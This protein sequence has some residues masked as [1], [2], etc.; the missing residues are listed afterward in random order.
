MTKQLF[1]AVATGQNVANLPPILELANPGDEV[2]WLQSREA[3]KGEWTAGADQVLKRFG[4]SVRVPLT[5][6]DIN[7][8]SRV[9][10]EIRKHM[11]ETSGRNLVLV[12]NGGP[13]LTTVGA[14]EAFKEREPLLVY[15][16]ERPAE[17][18][19]FPNGLAGSRKVKTYTRHRLDL[20]DV[21]ACRNSVLT[22]KVTEEQAK[23]WPEHRARILA[24]PLR[25]GEDEEFTVAC[26]RAWA[27][28]TDGPMQSGSATSGTPPNR[29]KAAF[30][31]PSFDL[32]HARLR[33]GSAA[34]TSWLRAC[35]QLARA[36]AKYTAGN[37]PG[38]AASRLLEKIPKVLEGLYHSTL[39]L[40]HEQ[41]ANARGGTDSSA[42][43]T[44]PDFER[45]V[46][47]RVLQWVE[48]SPGA[49]RAIQSIWHGAEIAKLGASHI[50]ET[51][52]DVLVVLKCGS[53]LH[54]ECKTSSTKTDS[55]DLASRIFKLQR[56]STNLARVVV[57][58]PLL[59]RYAD[60]SWF[61]DQHKLREL[62][63]GVRDL[64]YLPFTLPNQP[65]SYVYGEKEFKC[66]SFEQE[67]ERLVRPY[68]PAGDGG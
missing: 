39:K 29:E 34:G 28:R 25:Y 44:G 54:L 32:I 8:P 7:D 64:G 47:H 36:G 2:L 26:H 20:P 12:A 27:V 41:P 49:Q 22:S 61:A 33:Q 52:C 24:M 13:K 35:T 21:L 65:Q 63:A 60:E 6:E 46:V 1:I 57:C 4:L 11:S 17:L 45:V 9:I 53:L 55:K 10:A 37:D 56:G 42:F 51:E 48:R 14:W 23:I 16:M 5:V 31:P 67:L 15:G 18:W 38:S 43:L 40:A 3:R 30:V 19:M 50:S 62:A 59:S 66:P 68:I 58:G